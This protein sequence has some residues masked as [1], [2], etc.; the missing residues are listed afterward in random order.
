MDWL[1]EKLG[2]NKLYSQINKSFPDFTFEVREVLQLIF[3]GRIDRAAGMVFDGFFRE[4]SM[5]AEEMKELLILVLMIGIV[6]A[7]CSVL[8]QTFQNR[9][10][11]E[12][13]HFIAYLMMLTVV[14]GIFS[15]TAEMAQDM[16]ERLV[17]F[18]RLLVPVFMFAIGLASGSLTAF[19]YYQVILLALY[20]VQSLIVKIGI[21]AVKFFMILHIMNG[22][23]DENRLSGL[24]ELI[25]KGISG[26]AKVF[27]T[28]VAGMGVMQSMVAPVLDQ[29][30]LDT[31]GKLVS[32]IPGIGGL[33]EGAAGLVLGSAVLVRNG[34]GVAAILLI[35]A[36]CIHPFIYISFMAAL[37]KLSA[38]LIGLAA[39]KRITA[40]VD[41]AGDALFLMIRIMFTA[42]G[43]FIVIFA[44]IT[45]VA[46]TAK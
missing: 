8:L 21:S 25:K 19:G 16:L 5:E 44:I 32:Y 43:C 14:I 24:T 35:A 12:I 27:L 41:G 23:W 30:K 13:A 17:L 33:A 11:A 37:L 39:D 29:L 40:C 34:L 18:V 1:T 26:T 31:A 4:I 22:I 20:L 36:I 6:S 28:T 3:E 15:K 42:A 38:G 45:C 10:V 7:L 46:G 2:L 9:Q